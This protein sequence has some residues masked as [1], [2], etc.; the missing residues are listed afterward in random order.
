[1][2]LSFNK[3]N[4]LNKIISVQLNSI[5]LTKFFE[6][7][8][9]ILEKKTLNVNGIN[10]IL[11]KNQDIL[12]FL[13]E[14]LFP[15]MKVI[16]MIA[17]KIIIKIDL[18]SQKGKKINWFL[19]NRFQERFIP[20]KIEKGIRINIPVIMNLSPSIIIKQDSLL[21]NLNETKYLSRQE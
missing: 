12:V 5:I 1:M 3:K 18:F 13:N 20:P 10:H 4:H 19:L 14:N 7:V 17:A 8:K 21:I 15:N 6:Y 11:P 16:L 9:F 2:L